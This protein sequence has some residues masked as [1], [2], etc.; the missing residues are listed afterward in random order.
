MPDAGLRQLERDAAAGDPA[1][2]QRFRRER[3][4][5]GGARDP[6]LDPVEGDVVH[7]AWDYPRMT[8]DHRRVIGRPFRCGQVSSCDKRLDYSRRGLVHGEHA[9]LNVHWERVPFSGRGQKMGCISLKGWM[10]WARRGKVLAIGPD[11][12]VDVPALLPA[13]LTEKGKA[14]LAALGVEVALI[15]PFGGPPTD[16]PIQPPVHIRRP[17]TSRLADTGALRRSIA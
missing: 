11:P 8:P 1:A 7:G 2:V 9:N 12:V 4:R 15:P 3:L 6:R 14:V 10:T 17:G 13:L 5:R 16:G